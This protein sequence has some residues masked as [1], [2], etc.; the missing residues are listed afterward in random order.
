MLFEETDFLDK[1]NEP[2]T[3]V[4][5]LLNDINEVL[6]VG[7]TTQG[8]SRVYQHKQNKKWSRVYIIICEEKD[9]NRTE[10]FYINKYEPIYNSAGLCGHRIK[11][12]DINKQLHIDFPT[13]CDFTPEDIHKMLYAKHIKTYYIE[14]IE[15]ILYKDYDQI[16][17]VFLDILHGDTQ[18]D[19][20][21]YWRNN[22]AD[23]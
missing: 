14:D 10:S 20:I 18:E 1:T 15:Y 19:N 2:T 3:F 23:K 5:F 13:I 16:F 8:M 22:N 12:C 21:F 6:Y 9:L 7:Q 11:V 17:D 4:Y